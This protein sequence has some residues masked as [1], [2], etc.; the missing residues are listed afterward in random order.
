M[1][2]VTGANGQLG[3]ELRRIVPDALFA[4]AATLDI[5]DARRVLDFVHAHDIDLIINC[6]A[7]T[8]VD[9]A[10][11]EAEA[12]HLVNAVGPK[13]LAAAGVPLIHVSTDYVFDGKGCKPYRP[14]DA[15]RPLS[16][17]GK[18]KLDGE[19]AVLGTAKTAV[20]IRTQWLY[21]AYG[22]NFVKTMR[23]LG[24]E[25]GAVNVVADQ[26]GTPTWAHDLAA[27]IVKVARELK[28]GVRSVYHYSNSGACSWYDFAHAIMELSGIKCVVHPIK[29]E[30]YPTPA[31]RPPYSVLDKD[32][33]V[34][35]FG[36]T[37]PHWRD[38]LKMA[39]AEFEKTH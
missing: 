15:T 18:T 10:E 35:D 19:R 31:A 1:W 3:S 23:R 24:T 8:A 5:T 20:I 33:I 9:R 7:Y 21:S 16:V 22:N 11:S 17:Y 13:N 30:Q 26:I 12:A 36:V 4:D 39:L 2:L 34:R 38:S 25:R 28:P 37:V 32:D 14:S 6:A 27:A 29:T